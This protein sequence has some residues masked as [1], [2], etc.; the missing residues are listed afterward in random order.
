MRQRMSRTFALDTFHPGQSL[1]QSAHQALERPDF[2]KLKLTN[3]FL[4]RVGTK[5]QIDYVDR[6]FI[7]LQHG[8][9]LS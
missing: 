8:F 3:I 5:N 2:G 1:L 7:G 6:C 9:D 4:W